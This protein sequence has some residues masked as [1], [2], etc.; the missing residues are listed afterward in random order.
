MNKLFRKAPLALLFLFAGSPVFAQPDFE[1]YSDDTMNQRYDWVITADTMPLKNYLKYPTSGLYPL[2]KV[3]VTYR[4]SRRLGRE[5]SDQTVQYEELWYHEC[6]PIG[7]RKWHSLDIESGEQGV[8]HF[9]TSSHVYDHHC[10]IANTIIR[11]MLDVC[12]QYSMLS[13]VVI[14]ME[15]FDAVVSDLGQFNFFP[16]QIKPDTGVRASMHLT[17]VSEPKGRTQSMF[18]FTH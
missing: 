13:T 17:L 9:R 18:Y 2:D 4:M 14:P 8:I 11:L 7:C 6:K 1:E 16:Y 3:R 12:L 15:T 5:R 10:A